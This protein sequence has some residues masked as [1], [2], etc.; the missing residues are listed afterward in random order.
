MPPVCKNCQHRM[1]RYRYRT[2]EERYYCRVC[3]DLLW[4]RF[5]RRKQSYVTKMRLLYCLRQKRS[6]RRKANETQEQKHASPA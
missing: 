2:K 4:D 1:S 6:L 5:D 3:Y